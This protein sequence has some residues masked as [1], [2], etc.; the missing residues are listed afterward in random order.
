MKVLFLDFDGVLNSEG[1]FLYET[2]RRK[3]WKEQG[4]KGPV[5]QTLCNV[6]TS[7][8]QFVLDTYPELKVVISS[9]WRELFDLEWLKQH[10][11]SYHIDGHRVIGRTPSLHNNRNKEIHAWLKD[12]PEVTH[13]AIVDDNLYDG[14]DLNMGRFVQTSWETG[15]TMDKAKELIWLLSNENKE[16]LAKDEVDPSES[17]S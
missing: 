3:Q 17:E 9:T 4:V 10:L 5:N 2:R 8:L 16:K 6:C 11:L 7:N 1:S 14:L 13:Y 12:H 15:L